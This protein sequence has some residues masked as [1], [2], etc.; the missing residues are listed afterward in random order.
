M[1]DERNVSY[2]P[3]QRKKPEVLENKTKP[4]PTKQKPYLGSGKNPKEKREK[5]N[6]PPHTPPPPPLKKDNRKVEPF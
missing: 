6:T 4:K 3:L 2:P 5:N 1:G